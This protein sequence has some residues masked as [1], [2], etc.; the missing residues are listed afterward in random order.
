MEIL[1]QLF[2]FSGFCFITSVN[3]INFPATKKLNVNNIC[4]HNGTPKVSMPWSLD[5][6]N[7]LYHME[8]GTLKM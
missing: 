5:S 3:L 7:M 8:R 6:T 1:V 2:L 4:K